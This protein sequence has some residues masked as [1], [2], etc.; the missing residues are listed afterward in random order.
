MKATG[1]K[2]ENVYDFYADHDAYDAKHP[3]PLLCAAINW[4]FVVKRASGRK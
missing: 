1:T 4:A 2:N 3:P